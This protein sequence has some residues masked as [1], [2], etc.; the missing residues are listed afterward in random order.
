MNTSKIT[1]AL[2]TSAGDYIHGSN[3]ETT[4]EFSF[5][6]ARDGYLCEWYRVYFSD[7]MSFAKMTEYCEQYYHHRE[8]V[9]VETYPVLEDRSI[10]VKAI[11]EDLE[12][13]D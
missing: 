5:S 9:A 12:Y 1:M 2:Y 6:N 4:V 11:W 13:F 8:A 3:T 10:V 7:D